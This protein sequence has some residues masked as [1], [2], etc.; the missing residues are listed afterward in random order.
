[1]LPFKSR[2]VRRKRLF[3]LDR[4]WKLLVETL[5]FF[6]ALDICSKRLGK[7]D[8]GK[9]SHRY[10]TM[11]P[12]NLLAVAFYLVTFVTPY[13]GPKDMNPPCTPWC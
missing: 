9:Y 11:V 8:C 7:K 2:D 6:H 5:G 3:E 1:M 13:Q 4:A 12:Q 10:L